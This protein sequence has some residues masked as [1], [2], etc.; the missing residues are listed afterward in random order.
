MFNKKLKQEN[1]ELKRELE[2]CKINN[3]TLRETIN[4]VRTSNEKVSIPVLEENK[5]LI[6][7]IMTILHE[8]GTM[9]VRERRGIKIPVYT[10]ISKPNYKNFDDRFNRGFTEVEEVITIP[11]IQI[12][13]MYWKV[14]VER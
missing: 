6:N 3:E 12:L 14:E 11:E 2:L 4:V 1:E 8:F 9:E 13:K 5:K 10:D 7:W